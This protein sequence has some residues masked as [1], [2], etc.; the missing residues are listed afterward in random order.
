[1][2]SEAGHMAR[3][4]SLSLFLG[5]PSKNSHAAAAPPKAPCAAT[6]VTV[7]GSREFFFC[8]GAAEESNAP[9]RPGRSW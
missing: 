3:C 7:V 4:F 1:M 6:L 2:R 5:Q 9:C 8:R